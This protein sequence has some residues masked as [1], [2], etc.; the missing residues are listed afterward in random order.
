MEPNILPN[1]NIKLTQ[2]VENG[3]SLLDAQKF[4]VV[5]IKLILARDVV[6]HA[7]FLIIA[8]NQAQ[9]LVN[10]FLPKGDVEL[11]VNDVVLVDEEVHLGVHSLHNVATDVTLVVDYELEHCSLHI[12]IKVPSSDLQ[13]TE[14]IV[15]GDDLYNIFF[16]CLHDLHDF[17]VF[18]EL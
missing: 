17:K 1:Q 10:V 12:F 5:L 15:H 13:N 4:R 14:L 18:A 2:V 7:N 9:F 8:L 3:S 6:Y 11:H 16:A